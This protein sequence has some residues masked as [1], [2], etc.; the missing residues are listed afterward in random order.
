MLIKWHFSFGAKEG[1]CSH[2]ALP[3]CCPGLPGALAECVS[4]SMIFL[5]STAILS[6]F[7]AYLDIIAY[8]T[9]GKEIAKSR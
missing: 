3:C 4:A 9:Y 7:P 6:T 2:T 5:N 8:L 1:L